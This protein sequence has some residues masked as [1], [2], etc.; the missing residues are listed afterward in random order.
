MPYMVD[1]SVE[2]DILQQP[3]SPIHMDFSIHDQDIDGSAVDVEAQ[4]TEISVAKSDDTSFKEQVMEDATEVIHTTHHSH[5]LIEEVVLNKEADC[6][7]SASISSGTEALI[8]ALPNQ[9]INVK[10]LS[11][12]S[13]LELTGSADWLS[14][15]QLPTQLPVKESAH[16]PDTKTPAPRNRMPSKIIQ[17]PYLT[18]FGSS[19]KGKE[20]IDDDVRPLHPFEGCGILYQMSSCLMDEFS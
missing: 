5:V 17:S 3:V 1:D 12:I 7:T 11:S 18:S 9:P 4:V 8:C 20:K 10:P 15:S 2:K 19:D 6:T 16:Y 13:Q 14:D